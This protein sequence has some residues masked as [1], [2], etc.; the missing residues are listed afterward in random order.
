M[1]SFARLLYPLQTLPLLMKHTDVQ[2]IHT[3]LLAFIWQRRKP[4]IA[5]QKLCLP[6][7]EGGA[8]LPNIRFYNLSCLLRQGIVWLSKKSRYSNFMLEG[9]L[10][11][12][13]NLHAVLH[14]RL[15]ALPQPLRSNLL[16]KDTVIAWREIRKILGLPSTISKHLPYNW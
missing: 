1:V 6:K 14:S 16:I 9:A 12:P 13:F 2:K 7:C 10:V 15:R 11:F 4:C 8:G 3:A 5:L